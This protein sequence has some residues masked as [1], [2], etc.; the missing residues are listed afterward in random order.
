MQEAGLVL[1]VFLS[2]AIIYYL[3]KISKVGHE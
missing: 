3:N 1:A 2:I